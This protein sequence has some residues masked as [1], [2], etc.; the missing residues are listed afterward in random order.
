[1]LKNKLI[2][3]GVSGLLATGCF[4]PTNLPQPGEK[5]ATGMPA[6]GPMKVR[7]D[8]ACLQLG[9]LQQPVIAP[10][11]LAA[12]A[13]EHLIAGRAE[14]ARRHVQRFPDVSEELLRGCDPARAGD[15]G[16]LFVA[17]VQDAVRG[18]TAWQTWL[19]DLAGPNKAYAAKRAA[20]VAH[21]RAGKTKA[22]AEAN[23]PAHAP[24]GLARIDALRLHGQALLLNDHA[25]ESTAAFAEAA[26]L[27]EADAYQ[28]AQCLLLLGE[29]QRRAGQ[30]AEAKATWT[31]AVE[32]A[33]RLLERPEPVIDPGLWERAAY[34]KPVE[35][36]WPEAVLR[37]FVRIASRRVIASGPA[38]ATNPEAWVWIVSGQARAERGELHAALAAITRAETMTTDPA[39]RDG[40]AVSQARVLLLLGQSQP[41]ASVLVAVTGHTASPHAASAAALL[42]ALKLADGTNDQ[43]LSLLRRA[44]ENTAVNW[45]GRGEAEADLGLAYLTAGDATTGLKWLASAREKFQAEGEFELMLRSWD[46]EARYWDSQGRATEAAAARQN[47][48]NAELAPRR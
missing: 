1:M 32:A 19:R 11:A 43:A 30:T 45:P 35:A 2:A 13:F 25:K 9:E 31:R 6:D 20:V 44:V 29:S 8:G 33:G 21:L 40:L 16:V 28:S 41:A 14:T 46:N 18:D 17:A 48:R 36:V 24:A 22:A 37:S 27:A 15:S 26:T 12:K 4:G 39:L 38:G 23:L 42:G 47:I 34:L 10:E 3:F 7:S 5:D